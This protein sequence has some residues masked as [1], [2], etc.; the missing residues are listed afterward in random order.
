MGAAWQGAD[1]TDELDSVEIGHIIIDQHQVGG[2]PTEP[3][4]GVMGGS[5]GFDLD[6]AIEGMG[7]F[8]QHLPARELVIN[9]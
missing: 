4:Q 7:E 9:D 3:T 1:A 6:L 2:V 8:G 5:E